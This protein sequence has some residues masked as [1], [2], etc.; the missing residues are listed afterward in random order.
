MQVL[1]GSA[2]STGP[3]THRLTSAE[4]QSV[5]FSFVLCLAVGIAVSV[6]FGMHAY[7]I[8]TGQTTIEFYGN[9]SKAK[10]MHRRGEVFVNMYDLGAKQNW[11]DVFGP[12]PWGI[13]WMLPRWTD[14]DITKGIAWRTIA[15]LHRDAWNRSADRPT[16]A[17]PR[18]A[19]EAAD[20]QRRVGATGGLDMGADV[21]EGSG[22]EK[23][24]LRARV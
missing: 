1:S 19:T 4:V 8:L 15:D 2:G 23:T 17:A 22:D 18:I 16:A 10:S 7:L 11:A 13:E 14:V 12:S 20:A 5:M 21:S 6:L 9:R 3:V 24:P